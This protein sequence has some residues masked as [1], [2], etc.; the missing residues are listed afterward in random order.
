MNKHVMVRLAAV[1]VTGVL[2]VL[3]VTG[4]AH[5]A[6]KPSA[7]AASRD[8]DRDGMPDQWEKANGLDLHRNDA[9][10]D[11]DHDGLSN[12][13]EF[14]AGTGARKADTDADGMPDG[15]EIGHSLNALRNDAAADPDAD[16][17]TNR[18]ELTVAD[19]PHKAD[20]DAD[21]VPDGQ[22]DTDSDGVDDHDEF[23]LGDDPKKGDSDGDGVP[24]GQEH[25]GTITA[26]DTGTGLLT[27][28]LGDKDTPVTVTVTGTTKLSWH[29]ASAKCAAP[30]SLGDLVP[31]HLVHKVKVSDGGKGGDG[32]PH[33]GDSAR[34][35]VTEPAMPT[36]KE[37]SLICS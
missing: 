31:G 4:P 29:R 22:E 14:K 10:A 16:G 9:A 13:R 23:R 5:A 3:S 7:S 6:G 30:A 28:T 37:I 1:T 35:A 12:L 20:S 8:S 32:G 17:L 26:F 18:Q 27:V 24:D 21:G 2:A 15:W 33:G 19:D 11:P 34:T 36:A 25:S